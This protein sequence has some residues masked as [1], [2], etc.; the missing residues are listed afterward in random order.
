MTVGLIEL[1]KLLNINSSL[2][3]DK[4]LHIYTH[5]LHTQELRTHYGVKNFL[6]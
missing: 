1:F 6:T 2:N 3:R 4:T 5:T